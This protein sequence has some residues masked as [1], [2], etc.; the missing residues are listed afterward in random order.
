MP[1]KPTSQ[2]LNCG[3]RSITNNGRDQGKIR[4]SASG[5]KDYFSGRKGSLIAELRKHMLTSGL[6]V[7]PTEIRDYP[8]VHAFITVNGE[9]FTVYKGAGPNYY[10][11]QLDLSEIER[12]SQACHFPLKTE[13]V[14]FGDETITLNGPGLEKHFGGGA[15]KLSDVMYEHLRQAGLPVK[16]TEIRAFDKTETTL[17]IYGKNFIIQKG[18]LQTHWCWGLNIKEKERLAKTCN[19]APKLNLL[20][21]DKVALS[22]KELS[23]HF[24]ETR[25]TP[26]VKEQ[27]ECA[28]LSM[29]S[30]TISTH[31]ETHPKITINGQTFTLEKCLKATSYCWGLELADKDRFETACGFTAK[32]DIP[33]MD[34]D[35]IVLTGRG[36]MEHYIGASMKLLT[37]IREILR[38]SNIPADD[39]GIRA[40]SKP[41]IELTINSERF[42]LT[43]GMIATACYWSIL[44]ADKNRFGQACGFT[45]RMPMIGERS[46]V[47]SADGLA[48][49]FVGSP[50]T[51]KQKLTTYLRE[52]NLPIEDLEIRNF[53]A[54]TASLTVN[55]ERFTVTRGISGPSGCWGLALDEKKRF[56]KACGLTLRTEVPALRENEVAI[57]VRDLGTHFVGTPQNIKEAL[58]V[59]LHSGADEALEDIEGAS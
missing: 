6:P 44:P 28:G 54:P 39:S 48:K 30:E 23:K 22:G 24:V 37:R 29:D 34:R 55:Q 7:K 35:A 56:A 25:V 31:P 50:S 9:P 53:Q 10:F 40:F 33:Q 49:H 5:L 21:E 17:V 38:Q 46:I 3:T 58:E 41:S 57:S 36:L 12:F 13:I 8:E 20:G 43:R 15:Q 51:L 18:R 47:L 32:R 42:V 16:E 1:I 59:E 26:F 2:V 19:F 11:W 14:S 52:N 4:L 27:L 45:P